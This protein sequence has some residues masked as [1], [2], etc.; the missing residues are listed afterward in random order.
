MIGRAPVNIK[1]MLCYS[2]HVLAQYRGITEK[3][4]VYHLFLAKYF[5]QSTIFT[6]FIN[7]Y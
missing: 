1:Q 4:D 2:G 6:I 5:T 3:G 7:S